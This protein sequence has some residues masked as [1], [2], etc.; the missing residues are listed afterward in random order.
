MANK[1]K[2]SN[3]EGLSNYFMSL[4]KEDQPYYRKKIT[5]KN[6]DRLPDPY[7]LTNWSNDVEQMPDIMWYD[8]ETYLLDTPSQFTEDSLK[9]KKSLEA[10][11]YFVKG[12]V[13]DCYIH[14]ISQES[15]F[16]CLKSTV[17]GSQTQ[18]QVNESHDY[19]VYVNK[20]HGCILTANCSCKAG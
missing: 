20:P 6:G 8:V 16:C 10:H 4:P 1:T 15:E 13:H 2:D 3:C 19:W 11:I 18:G 14:T 9:A 17:M 5:L 12:H 7:L